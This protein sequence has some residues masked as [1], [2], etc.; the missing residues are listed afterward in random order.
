MPTEHQS[1][2]VE[3]R[4]VYSIAS[5][6]K[7]LLNVAYFR[8]I[9]SG[10][11]EALGLSWEKSACDLFNELRKR[12][13]EPLICRFSRD[14][15]ILELLLH[16]NG[17]APMNEYLLAPD[18]TFMMSKDAFLETAPQIA[19]DY[20]KGQKQ[21]FIEYSNGN[22]I[23]AGLLLEEITGL[24]LS[25]VMQEEVFNP[26]EMLHT[27]MDNA[28]LQRLETEGCTV[29][30]G[31]RVSGDMKSADPRT[32][33]MYLNDTVETAAI[34]AYSCTED[35]AKLIREFLKA[36]D[37]KSDI[38]T[39]SD[40]TYF[41]GPKSDYGDGGRASLAGLQC[42]LD[43]GIPGRESTNQILSPPNQYPSYQLGTLPRGRHCE[44]YYKAGA[45]DGFACTIY[46]SLNF[47]AFVIIL[48]NSSSPLDITDHI[49]RYIFQEAL[50]LSPKV[51]IIARVMEEGAYNAEQVR[52]FN[53]MD[54]EVSLW[55][56]NIQD[57]VGS[58]VHTKYGMIL[59]ITRD[60][61]VTFR[62][63]NKFSSSMKAGCLGNKLRI[64]PGP[65]GF[66]IDRWSVWKDRDFTL[67]KRDENVYLVNSSGNDCYKRMDV[68]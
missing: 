38:F 21:G 36:L 68:K 66:G 61:D 44:V 2:D 27:A 5:F 48:A 32:R 62:W 12:K 67:H 42:R 6:T 64:F 41:F 63:N 17:F 9:S 65:E 57:F 13:E 37:N 23:F 33:R 20:F 19:E 49:A 7:I 39:E 25:E 10:K 4:T 56:E 51:K 43:S 58:H 31:H 50:N 14:P 59:E 54:S 1:D 55:S 26:L 47:R 60:R 52:E 30:T 46:T 35:L 53:R 34:G 15:S 40:T 3:A 16:R 45:I 24:R 29:A 22:H 11:Y 28:T 18:G 8:I